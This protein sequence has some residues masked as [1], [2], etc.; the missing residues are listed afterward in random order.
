MTLCLHGLPRFARN[1][2]TLLTVWGLVQ[3]VG[4]YAFGGAWVFLWSLPASD[5][6]AIHRQQAGYL[7]AGKLLQMQGL[8]DGPLGP[9]RAYLATTRTISRHLLE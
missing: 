2:A 5:L 7:Q 6:Q 9:L 4:A 3:L 8:P 1:D